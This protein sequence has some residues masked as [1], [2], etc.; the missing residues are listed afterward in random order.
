[1]KVKKK[2]E[3]F[4]DHCLF[5]IFF[6]G[7]YFRSW[8]HSKFFAGTYFRGWKKNPQKLR[9]LIPAEINPIKVKESDITFILNNFL[10][11]LYFLFFVT[12]L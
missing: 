5:L 9:K 4:A 11:K 6:S 3:K 8:Q 7:I 12:I 1:M 2:K 10:K